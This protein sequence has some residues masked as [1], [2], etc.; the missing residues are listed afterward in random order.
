[1]AAWTLTAAFVF[2]VGTG[3]AMAS[4]DQAWSAFRTAVEKGCTIQAARIFEKPV[5]TVDPY[6]TEAQGVALVLRGNRVAVCVYDKKTK[7]VV[8][9]G[10]MPLPAGANPTSPAQR[11]IDCSGIPVAEPKEVVLACADAGI[12]A[13]HLSWASWS[14]PRAIAVGNVSVNSCT[15]SC[16]AGTFS[17]YKIALIAGGAKRCQGVVAYDAVSYAYIGK[18]P[19]NQSPETITYRC[20]S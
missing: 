13:E 19:P 10:L 20:R 18:A 5:V 17:T 3:S 14:G 16:V 9:S 6:G 4:S 2:V 15:P 8:L 11:L 7:H 12:T 1:M